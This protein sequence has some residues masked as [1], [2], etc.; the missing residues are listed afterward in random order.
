MTVS[1]LLQLSALALIDSLNPFTIATLAALLLTRRPMPRAAAF[2]AGTFVTYLAGGVALLFGI[3]RLLPARPDVSPTLAHAAFAVG[4]AVL[5][6]VGWRLER[7]PVRPS[8]AAS[9][10]WLHPGLVF[11]YAAASTVTDLPTAIPYLVAIERM[12]A[13]GLDLAS[14]LTVLIVYVAVY[15]LPLGVLVLGFVGGRAAWGEWV[16]RITGQAGR[17][18]RRAAIAGSYLFGGTLLALSAGYFLTGDSLL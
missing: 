8:T 18:G 15:C 17:W 6:A 12:N 5:L 14:S 9:P 10:R 13:R 4:G 7:T 1:F 16:Q 2:V 3:E 11:A